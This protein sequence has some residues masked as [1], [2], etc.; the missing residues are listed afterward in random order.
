MPKTRAQKEHIIDELSEKATRM[1][2][3]VFTSVG[4]YTMKDADQL[5]A[6]GREQGIE[7]IMAKKTLLLRAF[8]KTGLPVSKETLDGSVLTAFGFQ[9]E[10]APAKLMSEFLKERESMKIIGGLLE[11]RLIDADAV[12]QLASLPSRQELLAKLVG[13]L[14]APISGFVNV[15]VGNLRNLLYA[16]NAIRESKS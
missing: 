9:D 8:Q 6:K 16:L 4:G 13:S 11:G 2:S 10:I 5:R 15:L 1:K 12:Q 14:H 3:A 7:L